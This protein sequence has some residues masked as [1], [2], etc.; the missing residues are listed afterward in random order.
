MSLKGN[1]ESGVLRGK[2][3][4]CDILTISA[5]GIAVK[6]GFKGTEEEWLQSLEANP[7]RIK[8]F[9]NEYM[10]AN[11]IATDT[12]LTVSGEAADAKAVGDALKDKVGIN[13]IVDNLETSDANLPLSAKQGVALKKSVDD[14]G[15]TVRELDES[16]DKL[17]ESV[18][19][20]NESVDE[21]NQKIGIPTFN[22]TEM[23]VPD[24][25][26]GGEIMVENIDTTEFMNALRA[27]LVK[28]CMRTYDGGN[29]YYGESIVSGTYVPDG[30]AFSISFN[31]CGYDTNRADPVIMWQG[32]V[33]VGT[34]YIVA[35]NREVQKALP[36]WNG[37][38][39]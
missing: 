35:A 27:G 21:L 38:S 15:E 23:G 25:P 7:E 28:I 5:Y 1:A 6:N 8:Q 16:I 9:V 34:N 30:D 22:L 13:D 12:T 36:E 39:Y 26:Y 18:G 31:A 32:V 2:I 3:N 24:I 29:V 4:T 37:G 10:E 14:M 17:D 20:L 19:E 33:V 11:P